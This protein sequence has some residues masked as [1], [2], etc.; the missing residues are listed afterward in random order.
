M[1]A[2]IL[3]GIHNIAPLSCQRNSLRHFVAP[4]FH[5]GGFLCGTLPFFS[6]GPLAKG[7]WHG[8]AVT[9]GFRS[10]KSLPLSVQH[11]P[12]VEGDE[13]G[14]VFR[15]FGAEGGADELRVEAWILGGDH[16]V[17]RHGIALAFDVPAAD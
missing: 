3:V 2:L 15:V 1:D 4:P 17:H 5:K 16:Q 10:S 8:E 7:G 11:L 6:K 14:G 9:G 12:A 13:I